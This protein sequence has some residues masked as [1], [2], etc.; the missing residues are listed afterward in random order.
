MCIRDSLNTQW[1]AY[2]P[3]QDPPW[4]HGALTTSTINSVN[5]LINTLNPTAVNGG[6][7]VDYH[8]FT[9]NSRSGVVATPALTNVYL[10]CDELAGSTIDE[11]GR[12]NVLRRV[13]LSGAQFGELL[14]DDFTAGTNDYLAC[15]DKSISRLTFSMTDSAGTVLKTEGVPWS[16]S[17]VFS[18]Y[19]DRGGAIE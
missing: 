3:A 14:K 10:R 4:Q 19:G 7:G 8:G 6:T 18:K 17:L 16:F 2:G 15:H 13:N 5:G 11:Y 1:M 12:R 9:Q